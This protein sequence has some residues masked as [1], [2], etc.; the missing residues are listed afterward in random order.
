MNTQPRLAI[1]LW[2]VKDEAEADFEGTLRKLAEAGYEGVEFHPGKPRPFYGG[3]TAVELKKLVEKSGL[4]AVSSHTPFAAIE[5]NLDLELGYAT[6]LGMKALVIPHIP[7]EQRNSRETC[8]ATADRL[9]TYAERCK[10]EGVILCYHNHLEEL[11]TIDGTY[12]L[13]LMMQYAT[14]DNL[15]VE[16]DVGFVRMRGLNAAK[17]VKERAD[18][19]GLLHLKDPTGEQDRR[20]TVVGEG[21][22]NLEELVRACT[23]VGIDWLIVELAGPIQDRMDACRQS[24]VNTRAA[25]GQ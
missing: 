9:S 4:V 25:L 3:L 12:V 7:L 23:E 2:S 1:Q 18:K 24:L 21:L 22:L 8:K 10:Q 19:I 17:F 15:K 14:S 16:L 20:F 11:D 13:D 6:A 5:A